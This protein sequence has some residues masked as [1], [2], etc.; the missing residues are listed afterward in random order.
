[1]PVRASC[2]V[3]RLVCGRR[4]HGGG[5]RRPTPCTTFMSSRTT[6]GNAMHH[7]H[8]L[9]EGRQ[10]GNAMHHIHELKEGRQSGRS[11]PRGRPLLRAHSVALNAFGHRQRV[12]FHHEPLPPNSH[13]MLVVLCVSLPRRC[14]NR[15]H[16]KHAQVGV[17][18]AALGGG[19]AGPPGPEARQGGVGGMRRDQA[20]LRSGPP[21][22]QQAPE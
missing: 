20:G 13:A 6:P 4:P 10:S 9:K 5:P 11:K 15:P 21:G 17:V 1:M 19:H 8:E 3:R 22:G 18:D 12:A 2:L 7:I 14:S 16:G